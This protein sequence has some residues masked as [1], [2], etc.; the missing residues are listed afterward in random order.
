M[1]CDYQNREGTIAEYLMNQLSDEETAKF[2]EHF[3]NCDICFQELKLKRAAVNLI[4]TEG[5]VLFKDY[6]EGERKGSLLTRWYLYFKKNLSF[7]K[8]RVILGGAAFAVILFVSFLFWFKGRSESHLLA[9][10]E[11]SQS[12]PYAYHP[13]DVLR[14]GEAEGL[15]RVRAFYNRFSAAMLPYKDRHY[16]MAIRNLEAIRSEAEALVSDNQD[17]ERAR[18]A[19]SQ[20][21]FYLGVSHLAMTR[22]KDLDLT[23]EAEKRHLE[24]AAQFLLR[25]R[26]LAPETPDKHSYFLGLTYGFSGRHELA[27]EQL[28]QVEPGSSF[29]AKSLDLIEEWSRT[30]SG[31]K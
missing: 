9:E 2:Q 13:P 17:G 7:P 3:F 25:S 21:Y 19:A 18:W 12:V 10:F 6:L 20:Y 29:F 15:E 11:F 23:K 24:H 1:K 30:V 4:K 5:E 31:E 8:N 16:D 14:R 22:N 27:V 26:E 28:R